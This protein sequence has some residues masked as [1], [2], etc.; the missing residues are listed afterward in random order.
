MKYIS[1]GLLFYIKLYIGLVNATELQ[2]SM[3]DGSEAQNIGLCVVQEVY[4][5]FNIT[6][7]FWKLP[8]SRSISLSNTGKFDGELARIEGISKN[9]ENLIII[10][11]PTLHLKGMAFSKQHTDF[12][13]NGFKSLSAYTVIINSGAMF[14]KKGTDGFPHVKQIRSYTSVFDMLNR[15]R[16]DFAIA[17]YS[18]GLG[19][20]R[21][22]NLLNIKIHQPP[23]IEIPLFHYLHRKNRYL[24]LPIQ[25]EL[26]K[27]S[28]SGRIDDIYTNYLKSLMDKNITPNFSNDEGPSV[29]CPKQQLNSID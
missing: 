18:N 11:I 24:V 13:P 5:K 1:I 22:L 27:M 19:I 26:K 25:M 14:A 9:Y 12:T 21:R 23:L 17:P 7:S 29:P 2:F 6:T 28:D 20:L 4:R 15:D 16:G 3:L 8:S 10:P